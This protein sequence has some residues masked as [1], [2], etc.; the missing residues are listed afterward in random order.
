MG[1]EVIVHFEFVLSFHTLRRGFESPTAHCFITKFIVNK[2]GN[3]S[4]HLSDDMAMI[5]DNGY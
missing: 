4:P 1:R 3:L 5:D 2:V